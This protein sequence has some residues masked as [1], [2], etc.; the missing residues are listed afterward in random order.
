MQDIAEAVQSA[1]AS[2]NDEPASQPV[3][4]ETSEVGL[5]DNQADSTVVDATAGEQVEDDVDSD[6]Q[7]SDGGSS[8]EA[9]DDEDFE[10]SDDTEAIE[11][12]ED[13]IVSI[14]GK[15]D[16]V[17]NMLARQADYTR[18]TQALAEERK[19]FS[20][21]QSELRDKAQQ[22]VDLHTEMTE[23]Y[24]TRQANPVA[25]GAEIAGSTGDATGFVAQLITELN[26]SGALDPKFIEAFGLEAPD[27]AVAQ[28]AAF[29]KA[30][31]RISRLEA[32]QAAE[33]QAREEAALAAEVTQAIESE[34]N[35]L[36]AANGLEFA[37]ARERAEFRKELFTTATDY[38]IAD[39][40]KAYKV[41]TAAKP[42]TPAVSDE[43]RQAAVE[44]KRTA[45]AVSR[46]SAAS[47]SAPPTQYESLEEAVRATFT[48]LEARGR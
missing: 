7:D 37:T 5:E 44:R 47:A 41:M 33:R 27:N 10:D 13:T 24:S 48:E 25:W 45:R 32:E 40:S 9:D 18:K 19:A 30:Q 38:E 20:E 43:R 39:L 6:D 21:E 14:D 17:K 1:L 46:P 34:F 35:E 4:Q 3:E 26:N 23:W 12:T 2:M 29:G 28:A 16:T 8:D 31:E 11:L 42:A 36:I 15:K 22:V